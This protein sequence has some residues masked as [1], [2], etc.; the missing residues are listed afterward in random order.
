MTIDDGT[1]EIRLLGKITAPIAFNASAE[2]LLEALSPILNPN[3][4]DPNLPYTDNVAVSKHDNVFHVRFQGEHRYLSPANHD[5]LDGGSGEDVL[6]GQRGD[7]VL[8][9]G[10]DT[11]FHTAEVAL[12]QEPAGGNLWATRSHPN[13]NEEAQTARA[14]GSFNYNVFDFEAAHA[15][16]INRFATVKLLGGLRWANIEQDLRIEYDGRDFT[17]A[18]VS[19]PLSMDAFG[20]P[21]G[22]Q[23]QWHLAGGWT[24]FGRGVGSVMYGSFRSRLLETNLGGADTIVDVRDDSEAFGRST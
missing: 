4:D 7:D 8:G 22:L 14:L 9:G 24:L 23:G 5:V 21:L 17:N 11:Y 16:E 3:N 13:S 19:Q 20:V 1:F 10:D 18:V 15:F 6:F 12:A 2:D